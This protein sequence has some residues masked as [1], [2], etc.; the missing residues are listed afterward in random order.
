MGGRYLN[1]LAGAV[2]NRGKAGLKNAKDVMINGIGSIIK[3]GFKGGSYEALQESITSVIQSK[4][5]EIIY[6][7]DI[8]NAQHFRQA[9]HAGMIGFALGKGSGMVSGGMNVKN[10]TKVYEYLAPKSYKNQQVGLFYKLEE[11]QQDLENAPTSKKEKFQRVV[12]KVQKAQKDLQEQLYDRFETMQKEDPKSL[13]L[14]ID[15]IQEQHDNLDIINGGKNYSETAKDQ[16][17]KDF[18]EA[19]SVVGDLFA[20]T[21]INYDADIELKLSKYFRVAEDI[22]KANEKLWFKS[23]DLN[24]EY[25]DTQEK[26]NKL[27]KEYGSD[28]MNSAEGFFEVTEGGKRKIFINR[29]VAAMQDAS[30]VIGHELLHY[31]M[32]HRFANDPKFL[33]ESVVAFNEYL[34]EVSPYIKKS[35]ENR[36]ANPKN[37]YAKLDVDGKVQ[38]DEDGLIVM[39][40]DSWIE[41]YFTMFS[42][43]IKNEK[44]DVV[45]D[46]STGIKNKF[47]TM[48]RGLGLGFNKVDF[49]KR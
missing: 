49:Q 16:A 24:Y 23:K 48:V 37:G 32:S 17:K 30:N 19:A 20:V 35:I 6:G 40:N 14:M 45:E 18:K 47:R 39:N 10:K 38:R 9:L 11:A 29:D 43:L 25:V 42:D 21:D 8:S 15:K 22:D 13:E 27:K 44:I 7:D 36:L 5:D 34:D 33:R 4:G 12:D 28:I 31:A 3:T 41:E 2:K 1:K 46:A 26:F